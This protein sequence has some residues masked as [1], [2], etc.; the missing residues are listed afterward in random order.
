[1][2]IAVIGDLHYPELTEDYPF[3]EEDRNAFYKEFIERFFSVPADLYVSVGDLTNY[4]QPEEL[5]EIY[6]LIDEQHKPFVHVLGNHDVYGLTRKEVLAIT[7]QPRYHARMTDEVALAFIDTA[8]EQDFNDWGGTIDPEQLE[9]LC[10][11]VEKSDERPLIVFGHHPV[12]ATTT[13]SSQDKLCIHP[14]IPVWNVLSNSQANGLYVHGHNHFNS[15]AEREQWHFLQ[16]A[17]VLDQQAVRVIDVNQ[18]RITVETIGLSDAELLQRARNIG[19]A[20]NHFSLNPHPLG[21]NENCT[22]EIPLKVR[23]A[24]ESM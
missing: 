5:E 21:A 7:R 19:N 12:H 3:I 17:A 24:E 10:G 22:C 9:W 6:A 4:G 13:N 18:D 16:I 20:I 15:I 2:K 23:A 11:I 14:D 8:K 1:M